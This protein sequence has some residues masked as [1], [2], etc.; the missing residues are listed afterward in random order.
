MTGDAPFRE[1]VERGVAVM[2][3]SRDPKAGWR[4]FPGSGM[5]SGVPTTTAVVCALR[6]AEEAG[7]R[8]ARDYE[9]PVLAWLDGLVDRENGR[10]AYI[11]GGERLGYTPTTT[12]AASA[13]LMRV[14]LGRGTAD[15][16]VAL[17]IGAVSKQR[18]KWSI[19]F[20]RMKVN[21]IER[22]VQIGYLQHYYWYHATDALSRLGGS[23]WSAWNGA[24]KRALLPKQRKDGHAAG[25]WDPAG[26]YG[27]VAGRVYSTALC[28]LMLESY[29]RY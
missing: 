7:F 12:N 2:V 13:L 11:V 4:Y 18:P 28:T 16:E 5:V 27:K 8:V 22:D 3:E 19:R 6:V 20:K 10:V 15:D 1:E 24:L 17:G 29:Y 23:S 9:K 14:W 26:T 21:G 25:S